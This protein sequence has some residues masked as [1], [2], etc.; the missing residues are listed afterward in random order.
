LPD[1]GALIGWIDEFK[2]RALEALNV[3]FNELPGL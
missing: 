1:E 3:K 2:D